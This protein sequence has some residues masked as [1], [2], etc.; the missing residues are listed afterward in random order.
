[1][2]GVSVDMPAASLPRE[3]QVRAQQSAL[4]EEAV[5]AATTLNDKLPARIQESPA[6]DNHQGAAKAASPAVQASSGNADDGH[7]RQTSEDKSGAAESAAA[8]TAPPETRGNMRQRAANV[9]ASVGEN[10]RPRVEKLREA[11]TVVFDEATDDPGV[12][13]LIVAAVLFLLFLFFLLFSYI[14]G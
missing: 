1:M 10:L 2:D 12:R 5:R 6:S 11:S 13:F 14:L 7:V 8:T 9:G 4:V 3:P